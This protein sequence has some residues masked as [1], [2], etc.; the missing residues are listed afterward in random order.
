MHRLP[1]LPAARGPWRRWAVAASA[2]VRAVP[3]LPVAGLVLAVAGLATAWVQPLLAPGRTAGGLPLWLP[4]NPLPGAVSYAWPVAVAALLAAGSLV[5]RAR[6]AP[7]ARGAHRPWSLAAG[8][9]LVGASAGF[10]LVTLA[11]D[12]ALL[13]QLRSA[14][15]GYTSLVTQVGYALPRP[16]LTDLPFVTLGPDASLLLS[17]LR[18]GWACTLVAG[19][20]LL[21]DAAR[22]A[23]R[24]PDPAPAAPRAA[25]PRAEA[26]RAGA[27]RAEAIGARVAVV[28]SGLFV[29]A[30][31]IGAGRGVLAA[32]AAD[33]AA[34]LVADGRLAAAL[35]RYHHAFALDPRLV[36]DPGPATGY[37]AA[38]RRTGDVTAVPARLARARDLLASGRDLDALRELHEAHL[39][40]PGDRLVTATQ[41]DVALASLRT[42][43]DPAVAASLLRDVLADVPGDDAVL[44]L[45]LGKLELASGD[46]VAADADLRRALPLTADP[47][48]RSAA[49]TFA[50]V[51]QQRSGQEVLA[52]RTLVEALASDPEYRNLTARSLAVGLFSAKEPR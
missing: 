7:R 1:G 26:G 44:R 5:A 34:R 19:V 18:P 2:R 17:A 50:A 29:G 36:L 22:R 12:A 27:R 33:D 20:L 15:G 10:V 41:R 43:S 28:A 9:L 13:L 6:T 52:R 46:T 8:L 4:G 45:S 3:P 40:A 24:A 16:E 11:G 47:D 37:G 32:R 25:A 39:A 42:R 48:V 14:R 23:H 21:V 49:L 31:L 30:V 38:V 51:A 35:D